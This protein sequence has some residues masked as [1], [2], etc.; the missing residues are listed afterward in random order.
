MTP[1]ILLLSL[2]ALI[3]LGRSVAA[4]IHVE[5]KLVEI[6]VGLLERIR[7]ERTRGLT[8]ALSAS[9]VQ[10]IWA[11]MKPPPGDAPDAG[12]EAQTAARLLGS[13]EIALDVGRWRTVRMERQVR[14]VADYDVDYNA[15]FGGGFATAGPSSSYSRAFINPVELDSAKHDPK[16]DRYSYR[17]SVGTDPGMNVLFF[18]GHVER[19]NKTTAIEGVDFWLPSRTRVPL[20][21]YD[22][23][24]NNTVEK[25]RA[26]RVIEPR[27][28]DDNDLYPIR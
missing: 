25:S 24:G 28:Q 7:G 3:G 27:T 18:D 26:V 23:T 1:R 6:D 8:G 10:K 22:G 9:Q 14:F 16:W 12:A 4:G 15:G 20:D 17:H 2:F 5:V 21:E 19:M 13:I 11:G